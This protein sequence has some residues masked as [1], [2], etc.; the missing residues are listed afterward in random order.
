MSEEQTVQ[1]V[2]SDHISL[3]IGLE[4]EGTRYRS[5]VIDELCGKDEELATD[6]KK[7]QGNGA[8]GLTLVLCRA[9]QEISGLVERK[10]NAE[11]MV[12]RDHVRNLYQADRDFILSRML[13][14]ADRDETVYT[15]RCSCGEEFE[16]S[17]LIS[18]VPVVV[19]PDGKPCGFEF[20]LPKGV[21]DEKGVVH[22]KGWMRFPRGVE[23]E[24]VAPLARESQGRA[25]TAI[26]AACVTKIGDIDQIDQDLMRSLASRDREYL[27]GQVKINIP[28]LRQ[29]KEVECWSC[30]RTFDAI[31]DLT[32]FF[33]GRTRTRKKS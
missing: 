11:H 8:V 27:M 16:E 10:R 18:K 21:R 14:L 5:V 30:G 3:P 25:M 7:T 1:E 26:L 15:G 33:G 29:W 6:K 2:V 19:W 13:I 32:D 17:A 20:T 12:N 4:V 23:Q 24:L 9:I 28:G 22:T 31:V